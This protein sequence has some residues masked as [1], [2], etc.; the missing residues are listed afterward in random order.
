MISEIPH[1]ATKFL[2]EIV[3]VVARSGEETDLVGVQKGGVHAE[4]LRILRQEPPDPQIGGAVQVNLQIEDSMEPSIARWWM[5][6]ENDDQLGPSIA[7]E[8][9]EGNPGP[10]VLLGEPRSGNRG[11][12]SRRQRA[13]GADRLPDR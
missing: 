3:G 10:L 6:D 13:A 4:D 1:N 8:V 2:A 7:I 9:R 12:R 11:G 5:I